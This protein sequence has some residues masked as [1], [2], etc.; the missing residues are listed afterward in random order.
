MFIAEKG[1]D[2]PRINVDLYRLQQLSPEFLAINPA[3]TVPVLETD[4]GQY[5]TEG[6][7][8]CHY[9][10]SLAPEPP[11]FGS[12]AAARA[13]VLMW[14]TI[15]EQEGFAAVAEVLRN[16]SPGFRQHALP[17][18]V[19][20]PQMPALVERGRRR[21]EQFFDRVERQLAGSRYLAGDALSLADLS[22]LAYTDFAGWVDI[23]PMQTRPALARWHAEVAARPSARA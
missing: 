22:L 1:L 4:D 19:P 21:C 11:L 14:N 8:I 15:C 7:A 16:L 13:R 5:L 20:Y 12:S 2:I 10:E 17:G 3:G 9:L 6:V 23:V 18:P